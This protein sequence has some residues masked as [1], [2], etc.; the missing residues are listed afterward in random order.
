MALWLTARRAAVMRAYLSMLERAQ[1]AAPGLLLDTADV[2][3]A[4][5]RMDPAYEGEGRRG[6]GGH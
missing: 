4:E 1:A 3:L 6:P 5:A 2:P